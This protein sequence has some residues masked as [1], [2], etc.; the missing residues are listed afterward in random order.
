MR[1]SGKVSMRSHN[2]SA[3]MSPAFE[4]SCRERPILVQVRDQLGD[5]AVVRF[6]EGGIGSSG[7][8]IGPS[9]HATLPAGGKD[10]G[11][12]AHALGVEAEGLMEPGELT[13]GVD[14]IGL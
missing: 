7:G 6:Q 3:S 13:D 8:L 5:H 2:V 9:H 4:Q 1:S 12:H 10:G 14:G 11:V